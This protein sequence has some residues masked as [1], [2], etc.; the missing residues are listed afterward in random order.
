LPHLR[1]EHQI[2]GTLNGR[3]IKWQEHQMAVLLS[4]INADSSAN[5]LKHSKKVVS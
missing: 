1:Q 2:A 5:M 3:N 4:V